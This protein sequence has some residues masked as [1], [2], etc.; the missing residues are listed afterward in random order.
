MEVPD[1]KSNHREADPRIAL[2]TFLVHQLSNQLQLLFLQTMRTYIRGSSYM[3]LNIA[4][5]KC[6]F[7]KAHVHPMTESRNMV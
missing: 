3:C 7:D 5:E 6:T 2:H 4:L 1:L